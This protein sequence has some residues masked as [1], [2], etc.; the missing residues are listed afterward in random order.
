MAIHSEARKEY[1]EAVEWYKNRSKRTAERFASAVDAV[2]D[3]LLLQPDF[4]GRYDD[5]FRAAILKNFPYIVVYHVE[6]SGRV[7]I[8]AVAHTSREPGYWKERLS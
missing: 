7:L 3:Q 4:Y 5:N 6:P 8:I 2:F 1:R